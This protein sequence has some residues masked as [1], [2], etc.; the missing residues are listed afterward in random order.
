[1]A[2]LARHLS[3]L[4]VELEILEGRSRRQRIDLERV[5]GRRRRDL[6]GVARLVRP[7]GAIEATVDPDAVLARTDDQVL[8]V[9]PGAHEDPL[10]SEKRLRV[11]RRDRPDRVGC[12][13]R[14][15][16]VT[17]RRYED[18]V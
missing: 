6:R 15:A 2:R 14:S 13:P 3:A 1:D 17:R 9:G 12:R 5:A 8:V 18:A 16:V 10:R 4:S 7:A 11:A